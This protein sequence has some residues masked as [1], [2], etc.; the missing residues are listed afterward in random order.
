MIE[1]GKTYLVNHNRKGTFIVR[2]I[3]VDDTW[4]TGVGRHE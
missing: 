4:A 2:M 1:V 3:R